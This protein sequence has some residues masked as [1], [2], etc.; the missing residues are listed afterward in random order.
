MWQVNQRIKATITVTAAASKK[1]K[2]SERLQ[3]AHDSADDGSC[4]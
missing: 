2:V 1:E 4:V 3:R